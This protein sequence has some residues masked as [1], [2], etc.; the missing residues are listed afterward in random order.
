M[1]SLPPEANVGEEALV[2]IDIRG[3][4]VLFIEK[5]GNPFCP[6]TQDWG[7][8]LS[9]HAGDDLRRRQTEETLAPILRQRFDG[10]H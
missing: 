4:D 2:K 6:A 5:V 8:A 7:V 1:R 10:Y 9:L 3:L